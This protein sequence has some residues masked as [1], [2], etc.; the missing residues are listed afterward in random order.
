[1]HYQKRKK[2]T[3]SAGHFI[4]KE[5]GMAGTD[6]LRTEVFRKFVCIFSYIRG[7]LYR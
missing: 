6:K 2:L 4:I 7:E 3:E 5:I 1:M